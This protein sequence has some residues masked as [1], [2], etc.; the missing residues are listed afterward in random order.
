MEHTYT[1]DVKAPRAHNG[2]SCRKEDLD[3]EG[4]CGRPQTAARCDVSLRNFDN[5]LQYLRIYFA[6]GFA[7]VCKL[8]SDIDH[9]V[10]RDPGVCQNFA[11]IWIL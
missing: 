10:F 7:Q 1:E 2:L 9:M 3:E 5:W 11:F 4:K 6:T 8:F